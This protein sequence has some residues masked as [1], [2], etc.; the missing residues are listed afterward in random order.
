MTTPAIS[1]IV[2]VY[3]VEKYLPKCIDSI[4]AQTFTDFE[5]ILV[6]DGSSDR[7]G[8]ICDEYAIKDSR[9]RVIH[10]DNGGVSSARQCGLDSAVG[11]YVI[12]CDPDDWIEPQMYEQMHA[13]AVET[14]ADIVV[15]DYINEYPTHSEIIGQSCPNDNVECIRLMLAEELHG[16]TWNK[17]VRRSVFVDHHIVFPDNI[18]LMEDLV[19]M[20]CV[21]YYA[22]TISYI[23]KAYYHY[24][25]YNPQSYSKSISMDACLSMIGV[26]ER[27]EEFIEKKQLNGMHDA[28]C[29]RKLGVKNTLLSNSSGEQQYRWSKLYPEAKKY[30]ISCKKMKVYWRVAMF[31]ACHGMLPVYNGMVQARLFL[32]KNI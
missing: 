21:C 4:L 18:N 10:K 11:E 15:T 12:H 19:V 24:V 25:Q 7:C 20:V 2:P 26:L 28:M 22:A 5:V 6:D 17:L 32:K 23:P 16:S 13:K 27:L 31:F 9:V 8:D 30:V 14:N 3:N 29:R 1:V